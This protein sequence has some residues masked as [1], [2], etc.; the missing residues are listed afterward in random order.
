MDKELVLL[1]LGAVGGLLVAG[2]SLIDVTLY[3]LSEDIAALVNDVPIRQ[4]DH[5]NR[6]RRLATEG[7]EPEAIRQSLD[8]LVDEELLIQRG[9]ELNLTRLDPNVRTALLLAVRNTAF[10][11]QLGRPAAER[12]L[13]A[14]FATQA[15]RFAT[16]LQLHLEHLLLAGDTP[17]AALAKIQATFITGD[18]PAA[19][20][21]LY[22]TNSPALPPVPLSATALQRFLPEPVVAAA[23]SL[24]AGEIATIPLNGQLH[25][26]K[27]VS[28]DEP[29]TPDFED[30]RAEIE[31]E[32]G[33]HRESVAFHDYLKWLRDRAQ[34]RRHSP[35]PNQ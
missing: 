33:F 21:E 18:K 13:R 10:S 9:E 1:A 20:Q 8:A 35:E 22:L 24:P 5:Q 19:G 34:I 11:D 2:Y 29:D 16:P 7:A 15:H 30:I 28:R 25:L 26:L 4:V 23:A 3:P 27:A 32:Y 17:A 31:I 14:F 6:V 12:E